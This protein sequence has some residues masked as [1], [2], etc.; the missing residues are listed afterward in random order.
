MQDLNG[1]IAWAT[2]AGS[3][4]GK[5]AA[6]ALAH[7]GATVVLTGRRKQP[8]EDVARSVKADGG[9]AIVQTE[10]LTRAATASRVARTYRHPGQ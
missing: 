3:S 10:D 6:I 4:I 1:K 7:E 5:A 9:N 8:R 2:G